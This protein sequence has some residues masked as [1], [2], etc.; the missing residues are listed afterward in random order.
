ME[1][2]KETETRGPPKEP[3]KVKPDPDIKNE[4]KDG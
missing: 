2:E 1:N 3:I 4:L